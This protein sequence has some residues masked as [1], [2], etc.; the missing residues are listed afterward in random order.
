M[1]R[2]ESENGVVLMMCRDAA[3]NSTNAYYVPKYNGDLCCP[4]DV[5]LTDVGFDKKASSWA[6]Y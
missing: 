5:N 6:C 4:G 3:C 2:R 1:L